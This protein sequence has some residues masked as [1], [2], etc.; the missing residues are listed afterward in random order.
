MRRFLCLL[1]GCVLMTGAVLPGLAETV[2]A[3]ETE[4]DK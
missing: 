3:A 2:P 1:L 4:E